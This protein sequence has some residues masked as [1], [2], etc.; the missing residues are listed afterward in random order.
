MKHGHPQQSLQGGLEEIRHVI[1]GQRLALRVLEVLR[2]KAVF[3]ADR[4]NGVVD[5][6]DLSSILSNF[7][8]SSLML[9]Q[10]K[11]ECLSMETLSS[12]VLDFEGKARAN[13]IGGP[14]RCFLLG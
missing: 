3:E 11:L 1:V 12:Q 13:S 2:Y 7:F 9:S 8:T 4:A 10:N 6:L 5:I 14:F